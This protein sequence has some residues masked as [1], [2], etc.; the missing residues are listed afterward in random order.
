MKIPRV[1]TQYGR[2]YYVQDLEE[3]N[4]K[5]GRPKQRWI[6]L[7]RVDA[8]EAELHKALAELLG[9]PAEPIGNMPALLKEF[10]A[11]HLPGLTVDVRT[12]YERMYDAIAKGFRRFDAGD[13]EP[14]DV[15]KFLNDNFTG[16]LNS[17]GK[18][19]AR[20]STFFSWCVLNSH[21]G[22]KV[23][24][25]REIK[26]SAPPRRKGKMNAAIY[27]K[28][29]EA[30]TPMGQCFLELTYLSRQRP[31]EIRLLR[32]SHVGPERIRFVPTKTERSSAAEVDILITPE[33]RAVL[34]R[35]RALRPHKKVVQ[36]E[37]RRDAFII[38]TRDG[39]GFSKSGFYEVWRDALE[40]AE[41]LGRNI[42]T[43]DIRPFAGAAM[44]RLGYSK[45]EIQ[46]S[47]AHSS[48]TTTEVY[49]DQHRDRLSD[50]RLPLPERKT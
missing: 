20:L 14:G 4:P 40:K 19:K 1:Y 32:D 46:K 35:A 3:R 43:R 25:C 6:A 50:A 13:V 8:G 39:G 18:Y 24:P 38:Q 28:I 26:L 36:L 27:W 30:L 15:I 45:E 44:E 23:N 31:T 37:R 12:E 48:V 21:A 34:E 33:I 49:L 29:H 5:S 11:V 10:R 2:Y 7:T 41:L 47:F 16:K 22:V 42:T 9:Q 17:K